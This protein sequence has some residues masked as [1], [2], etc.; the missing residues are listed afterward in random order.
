MPVAAYSYT[1]QGQAQ[2]LDHLFVNDKFHDDL[3]QMRAAHVNAGWPADF[4]GDGPRGLSDHDPQVARFSSRASLSVADASVVEGNSGRRNAVFHVT[5]SR[6]LSVDA[7]VCLIPFGVTAKSPSDFDDAV[8][9]GTL[10]AGQTAIDLAV[11]VKG[12]RAREPDEVFGA[13]VLAG[14]GIRLADPFAIGTIVNDD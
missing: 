4:P 9:C 5:V 3:V 13:L 12:D 2:T 1:F 6:P 7:P 11:S 8:V 14:G 10:T